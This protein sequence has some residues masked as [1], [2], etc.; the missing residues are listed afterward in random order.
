MV[1]AKA[2]AKAIKQ[3]PEA[4]LPALPVWDK[5]RVNDADEAVVTSHNGDELRR[6]MWDYVGIVHTSKRL[7]RAANRS[8]CFKV[9]YRSM[10]PTF[11]PTVT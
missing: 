11:T 3:A 5:S 7:E 8:P 1:F 10:T 9:K 6:F 4:Q 2:T